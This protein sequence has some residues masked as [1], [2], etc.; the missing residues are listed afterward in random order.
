MTDT[1]AQLLTVARDLYLETGA[2][3]F[4]LREVARR[5]GIT[6]AGVYRHFDS[7]ESLL[8]AASAQGFQVFLSYLLRALSQPTPWT[9]L[10][11]T[12]EQYLRFALENPTDYRFI[13]MS[14]AATTHGTQPQLPEHGAF[15]MLVD[16]VAECM[17]AGK[18]ARGNAEHTSVEIWAHVH[19]LASLRL[20]GHLA[21]F[22]D[23]ATFAQFY[24]GSVLRLLAGLAPPT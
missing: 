7:K 22:G 14:V 17:E 13:F 4:S 24:A 6:A 23:E 9:R 1:R 3:S 10:L 5:V 8:E 2:A 16:R 11:H 19:G 21:P 20:A 18:I 12:G 15:R